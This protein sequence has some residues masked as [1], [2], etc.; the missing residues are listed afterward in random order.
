M[1]P[2]PRSARA[3][4]VWLER[5]AEMLAAA[6]PFLCG[7]CERGCPV[8]APPISVASIR[9]AFAPELRGMRAVPDS[10]GEMEACEGDASERASFFE[11]HIRDG[12]GH[13]ANPTPSRCLA[14]A[15]GPD[16]P[17]DWVVAY[18]KAVVQHAGAKVRRAHA[19]RAREEA[20]ANLAH[21]LAE[22]RR[23]REIALGADPDEP[24]AARRRELASQASLQTDQ[25]E[26]ALR[27]EAH[28]H[29]A[30]G[31]H[32]AEGRS[33]IAAAQAEAEWRGASR[34]WEQRERAAS[35]AVAAAEAEMRRAA[36]HMELA[37]G[38]AEAEMSRGE[39]MTLIQD[40]YR[41][42]FGAGARELGHGRGDDAGDERTRDAE[43]DLVRARAR[44]RARV[45]PG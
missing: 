25:L 7:L 34:A 19:A 12:V 18:E 17:P 5:G 26:L 41:R 1:R 16:A 3:R 23:L 29:L 36:T 30:L 38:A 20:E 31:V 28:K 32:A 35:A 21:A 37:V 6:A 27:Q 39:A 33:A 14:P 45:S 40:L 22:V 10:E 8:L 9:M 24:Q 2:L 4:F 15:S 43:P 11:V 13:I 42:E 44:A